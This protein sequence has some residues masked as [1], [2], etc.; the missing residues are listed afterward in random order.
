VLGGKYM[1]DCGDEFPASW[2]KHARLASGSR[3]NSLNYFGVEA[4][5]PLSEWHRKGWMHPRPHR[6]T[7]T[8]IRG[9]VSLPIVPLDIICS[10]AEVQA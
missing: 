10:P 1:T 5:Q 9:Y 7:G 8:S 2:Y 4:S 6:D 3:D